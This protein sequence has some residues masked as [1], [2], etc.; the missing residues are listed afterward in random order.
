[1]FSDFRCIDML[2]EVIQMGGNQPVFNGIESLR[3]FRVTQA[4]I[5]QQAVRMG[6]IGSIHWA[7]PLMQCI[8]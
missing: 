8:E 6:D 5:M 4:G 3:A 1:M 2:E 7:T